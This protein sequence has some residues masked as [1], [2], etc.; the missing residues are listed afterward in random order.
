MRLAHFVLGVS[1]LALPTA[2]RDRQRAWNSSV[3]TLLEQSDRD[4][5]QSFR[6]RS[7]D[8]EVL[9]DSAASLTVN[10][11]VERIAATDSSGI[12]SLPLL[13]FEDGPS[14]ISPPDL[15][16][17]GRHVASELT[18]LATNDGR[19]IVSVLVSDVVLTGDS[20][21]IQPSGADRQQHASPS[22]SLSVKI[23]FADARL[24]KQ[25]PIAIPSGT[26]HG[27]VDISVRLPSGSRITEPKIELFANSVPREIA[28]GTLPSAFS[29]GSTRAAVSVPAS[30]GGGWDFSRFR[31]QLPR[32]KYARLAY[33]IGLIGFTASLLLIFALSGVV[34]RA[35]TGA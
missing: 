18:R 30:P 35:S 21:A 1:L 10:G 34:S 15:R 20:N 3:E 31:F 5:R 16:L 24:A 4:A 9:S 26:A 25:L 28:I 22:E 17:G 6:Q 7:V 29:G 2:C 13:V 11:L 12:L 8:I 23:D 19:L 14:Y 32:P 33:R 27:I